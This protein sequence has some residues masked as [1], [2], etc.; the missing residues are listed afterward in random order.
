VAAILLA[1]AL[2]LFFVMIALCKMAPMYAMFFEQQDI[3]LPVATERIVQLSEY[4]VVYCFSLFITGMAAD[5]VVVCFLVFAASGKSWLLSAYS[6]L[7]L[8]AA[9][10]VLVYVAAW[11]SHP[12]Y[13][14]VR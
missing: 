12:V 7:W 1:H 9:S 11:L 10:A 8:L 6:H 4:C 14:L 5:A 2:A 13:S 3:V